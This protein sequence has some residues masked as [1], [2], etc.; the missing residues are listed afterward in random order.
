M[1]QTD[2]SKLGC[3]LGGG[4]NGQKKEE[5]LH[6]YVLELIVTKFAI[7]AFTKGQSNIPIHLQIDN[8]TALL[9]LLKMGG[10]H[11]R[12]VLHIT[13]SIWSFFPSKQITMSAKYVLSALNIHRD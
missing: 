7:L 5:S 11:K 1:T 2:V 6:I 12:E 13:K 9:Y 3:E 10:T 4:S 8:N